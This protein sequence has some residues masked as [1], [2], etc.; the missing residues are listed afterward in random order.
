[1]GK[2]I[3]VPLPISD[4]EG[5]NT[6]VHAAPRLVAGKN[7]GTLTPFNSDTARLAVQAREAKKHAV[8]MKALNI[9]VPAELLAEYGDYAFMA[10]GA[11][12]MQRLA[13]DPAAGKAAVMAWESILE[14]TGHGRRKDTGDGGGGNV[15]DLT[16]LLR[17]VAEIAGRIPA[18]VVD[19]VSVDA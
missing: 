12:N 11:K 15:S 16:E 10:E 5:E 18:D 6:I 7:G 13:S 4:N 17:A 2:R 19:A 9:E 1:M 8:M 3:N 14:H